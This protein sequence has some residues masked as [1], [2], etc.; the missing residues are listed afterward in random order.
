MQSTRI[1]RSLAQEEKSSLTREPLISEHYVRNTMPPIFKTG[2][3]IALFLLNVFWVTNI[4]PIAA[5]GPAGFLYWILC[6][7]LFFIPC[8]LVMAQLATMYPH[9]GSIYNWTNHALGPRWSFFV[10]ICAWLP[11]I[12]SIVNAAAAIISW[13]QAIHGQWLTATWQQGVLMLVIL[14][15]TGILSFQPS[16]M[17]QTLLNW[18][19]A[20]MGVATLIIVAAAAVWLLTGHHAATNFADPSGWQIN[21]SNFALLGSAT[22]ALLGSDMPLAMAGEMKESKV[23]YRH[24]GWGTLLTIG[25]YLLFTFA[26]LAVQGANAAASTVNPMSLLI[27]TVVSVFGP[28]VGN[29]MALCLAFYFFMIPVALHLCFARIPLVAAIDR[30]ISSW[31]ARL[32]KHRVPQ[33][34]IVAQISITVIVAAVIYFLTPAIAFLGKPEDLSSIAYNVLGASLLLVWAV[35]FFF[36]FINLAVLYL[37]DRSLFLSKRIFPVPLLTI[38]IITGPLLCIL[39]IVLTLFNSF[40]PTLIPNGVWWYVIGGIALACIVIFFVLSLLTNSEASW[41]DLSRLEA[42]E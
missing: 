39:T 33:N 15:F 2:G 1:E 42:L 14:V 16:R 12:L 22:L 38:C 27:S 21:A 20:A 24:L 31:F 11:G 41:E 28:V 40:I 7:I 19:A 3:M 17:L 36:P 35:S 30:R 6:G 23:I 8:S 4:T 13:I 32:N 37:K 34:T 9:E 5:G 26:V 25:G 10:G 18:A 29:I